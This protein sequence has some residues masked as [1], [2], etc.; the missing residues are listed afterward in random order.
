M[1]AYSLVELIPS[2]LTMGEVFTQTFKIWKTLRGKPPKEV[3]RNEMNNTIKIVGD[4]NTVVVSPETLNVVT[5][6]KKIAEDLSNISKKMSK[7]SSRTGNIK[8]TVAKDDD[9]EILELD[10]ETVETLK[11]PVFLKDSISKEEVTVSHIV[12]KPG[13][14]K[15]DN[16]DDWVFYSSL[17]EKPIKAKI[18]DS[19]FRRKV[20]EGVITFGSET[21]IEVIL[22]TTTSTLTDGSEKKTT[23]HKIL[24]VEK[25]IDAEKVDQLKAD[26]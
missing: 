8:L 1:L 21:R 25:V 9:V 14:V 2:I 4:N 23:E 24:K 5:D 6:T 17:S 7:D 16:I 10:K 20:S 26:I 12:L 19:E 15:F 13:T 3:I 22:Q 18:E 11:N